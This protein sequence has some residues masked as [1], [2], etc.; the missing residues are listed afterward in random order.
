MT[1]VRTDWRA[2]RVLTPAAFKGAT[3]IVIV[4]ASCVGKTTLV[5]R[6][7]GA[8]IDRVVIPERFVTR[9]PRTGDHP[10]ETT[11]VSLAEI[12]ARATRG[13]LALWWARTMEHGRIEH[14]G[15]GRSR[16]GELPIYSANNALLYGVPLV[17]SLDGTVRI[18]ITAPDSDRR[19]R[20]I[21]RSPD[22]ARDRSD[23]V[24]HRLAEHTEDV[25]TQLD[26]LV[27]NRSDLEPVAGAEL[28]ELVTWLACR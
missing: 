21:A 23:E 27:D 6:I 16:P 1:A 4:G 28:V 2:L 25:A 11:R 26:V 15:F 8:A 20:L 9:P 13:E 7:R 24:A 17:G 5:D 12:S 19:A 18:G 10:A 22:L 3:A 14:Y